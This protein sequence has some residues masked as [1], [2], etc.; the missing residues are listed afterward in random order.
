VAPASVQLREVRADRRRDYQ[1]ALVDSLAGAGAE[2][3][4]RRYGEHRPLLVTTPSV[5]R[6]HAEAFAAGLRA[7][8]LRVAQVVVPCSEQGKDLE[9][10]VSLCRTALLEKLGRVDVL[11][12]MGGGVCTDLTT[13][14]AS[15]YRR[16]IQHVRIPTTLIGQIDAS[17][18]IKGGVNFA[19]KKSSLGC[20]YAPSLVLIDPSLL[21]TLPARQLSSGTAEMLKVGIAGNRDLFEI[22]ERLGASF[23]ETGYRGPEA[24]E[25]IWRSANLLLDDLE[26]NLYEDRT[27]E[28]LSDLGHTISPLLEAR[29]GFALL[30]GEAVAIDMAFSACV[31]TR[32]GRLDP[33]T[34][35]RILG[36]LREVGLPL[37]SPHLD[38]DLCR[39]S[40]ADAVRHRGG[41]LNLVIPV[42]LGRCDFVRDPAELDA[43]LIRRALADLRA[44]VRPQSV[45]GAGRR[46]RLAPA[47]GSEILVFDVGGTRLR[48]G[49]YSTAGDRLIR[50]KEIPTPSFRALATRDA[51]A[52]RRALRQDL[53][54]LGKSLLDG[55][56]PASV[57]IAFA[58]PVDSAGRLLA[59]PTVW[60]DAR[61]G[62]ISLRDE[63]A[64]LWPT[65]SVV[66]MNDVTAAGYR[67]LRRPDENLCV[68][69][70][71]SGIGHKVFVDGRP[72]LGPSGR[73]GEIGH[74][75]VDDS[76]EAPHC[77][78][79]GRG[80]LGALASG[81]AALHQVTR[82]AKQDP[83]AFQ[84]S[85][86]GRTLG[87]AIQ[88]LDNR[89]LV[90]CF[91][92]GDPF[93]RRVIRQM[94]EPLGRALAAI[95]LAVGTERF[96][97]FG[98]FATALGPD[99]RDL[100]SHAAAGAGWDLGADWQGMLELGCAD[101]LDGIVGAGRC[102]S[103]ARLP[104]GAARAG[105][106]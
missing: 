68:V 24:R 73:G 35:D 63:L 38:A 90:R 28:R 29:S 17:I 54:R 47:P 71:S 46:G 1:L 98:G 48:G 2:L 7:R 10:A 14:A 8:G 77:E 72:V 4:A 85:E 62:P 18:G 20:F 64:P 69:T 41:C 97:I 30:H 15:L 84:A 59:A 105:G 26:P 19:G 104:H 67:Y 3:L 101:G 22:V 61:S 66:V 39:K 81:A 23:I 50:W 49:I 25:A 96:V 27:Y 43:A 55:R 92:E 11:V 6:L 57:S 31:A 74:W 60:G 93:A 56:S 89:E 100:V 51:E 52:V 75:R 99:Y 9:S 37:D 42:G 95:H 40:L 5:H 82:L 103:L 33:A 88:E 76:A 21:E 79:G 13:V 45:A 94:A 83:D 34:R 53:G 58:G 86:L 91:L 44:V 80:H 65:A 78:C 36:A 87:T 12:G 70:V 106:A 32:L 102:A 16:G